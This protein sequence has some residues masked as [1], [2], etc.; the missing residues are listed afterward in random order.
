[1]KVQLFV[2][3][4]LILLTG[5]QKGED[6]QAS[7]EVKRDI[8]KVIY[9]DGVDSIRLGIKL[10]DLNL[11]SY[12]ISHVGDSVEEGNG[13]LWLSRTLHLKDGEL[14]LEGNFIDERQYNEEEL[15]K[16]VLNRVRISDP[17]FQTSSGLAVGQSLADIQRS[18]GEYQPQVTPLPQVG[19][20][21]IEDRQGHIHY[22]VEADMTVFSVILEQA[23]PL[24]VIPQENKI[25]HIV[26]M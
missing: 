15:S 12:N 20:V 19:L 11:D 22:L 5:C 24:S 4:M 25:K 17:S 14:V 2:W 23:N 6:Q 10:F 9:R 8:E 21:D 26:V 18:L 16:S 1:M 7:E 13:Y 3:A